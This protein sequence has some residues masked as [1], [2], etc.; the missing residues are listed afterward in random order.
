MNVEA[1]R[2]DFPILE[3]KG[4]EA[5]VYLDNACQTLRP[6]AVL[7]AMNGYYLNSSACSGR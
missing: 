4:R 2:R 3:K 1:V 5:I 6:Q 7:D